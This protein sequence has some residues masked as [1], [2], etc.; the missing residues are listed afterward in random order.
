[1]LYGDLLLIPLYHAYSQVDGI[2]VVSHLLWPQSVHLSIFFCMFY[3][4]SKSL[5]FWFWDFWGF[6]LFVWFESSEA[7]ESPGNTHQYIFPCFYSILFLEYLWILS[8]PHISLP[9]SFSFRFGF[10]WSIACQVWLM[11]TGVVDLTL[12]RTCTGN[13]GCRGTLSAKTVFWSIP[14]HP[15]ALAFF[16]RCAMSLGEAWHRYPV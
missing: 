1:M 8:T 16:L 7:S 12:C 9:P 5:V 11:V 15:P 2:E 4:L 3:A 10:F 6:F 13:H 14:P